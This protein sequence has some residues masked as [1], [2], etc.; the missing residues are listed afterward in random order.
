MLKTRIEAALDGM[1]ILLRR[2]PK[3]PDGEE[4]LER[5]RTRSVEFLSR[6]SRNYLFQLR[7]QASICP[8]N[9]KVAAVLDSTIKCIL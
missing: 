3:E 2:R 5:R 8:R 6:F 4:E 1:E 7:I 9:D